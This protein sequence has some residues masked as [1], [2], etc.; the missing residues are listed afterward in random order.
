MLDQQEQGEN[1][2][3]LPPRAE[4]KGQ[5]VKQ[6][7]FPAENH[8]FALNGSSLF[9]GSR[10]RPQTPVNMHRAPTMRNIIV[11]GRKSEQKNTKTD[12]ARLPP[13]A[14]RGACP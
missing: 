10:N 7:I 3:Y 9:V 2:E 11:Y 6:P 1:D 8:F 4:K 5:Q 13:A 12:A 14:R